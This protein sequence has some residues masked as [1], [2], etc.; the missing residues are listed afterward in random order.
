MHALIARTKR[1]DGF[2]LTLALLTIVV[3]LV[4]AGTL[5]QSAVETS[6]HGNADYAQKRATAAANAGLQAALYRLS[7]QAEDTGEQQKE[8]FTT[9]YV[10]PA[11]CPSAQTDSLGNGAEYTYY[12]SP[13]FTKTEVTKGEAGCTGLWVEPPTGKELYQRCITSIGHAYGATVRTQERVADIVVKNIFPTNGLFSYSSLILNNELEIAGEVGAREKI[14][15]QHTVKNKNSE[16]VKV[17]Y[18]TTATLNGNPKCSVSCTLEK[19]GAAELSTTPYT[20]PSQEETPFAESKTTN[21]NSGMTITGSSEWHGGLAKRQLV[22]NGATIT[23]PAGSYNLCELNMNGANTIKYAPGVKIYLDSPYRTGSGGS[24]CENLTGILKASNSV[25]WE[26]SS[27][28]P[29]STD[30]QIFVWGNPAAKTEQELEHAPEF[31][32]DSKV[33]GGFYAMIYAPYSAVEWTGDSQMVG[34]I[35]GGYVKMTNKVT[36]EGQ[37]GG[38]RNNI[39]G[40]RFYATAYH[41][42]PPTYSASS[43]AAGCY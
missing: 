12:V 10:K 30:L 43:P 8:C 27:A 33:P 26:D 32:L 23:M 2:V 21:N 5:V 40:T 28:K 15:I 1:E 38:A 13:A 41:E 19:L 11:S 31:H 14:E 36:I 17:L 39:S 20:E 9:K 35:V 16:A 18:G 6:T 7:N 37:G 42:C 34:A 25:T 4:L 24:G 29:Q 3:I 22:T